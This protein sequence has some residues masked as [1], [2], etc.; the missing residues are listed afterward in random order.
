MS[1]PQYNYP[2]F[3]GYNPV[4]P[5]A[6]R[7]EAPQGFQQPTQPAQQ[8][9]SVATPPSFV[10]RPV[11]SSE[12]AMAIPVDFMGNPMFFPDLAHGVIY[13][14]RFNTQTG[15]ADLFEYYARPAERRTEGSQDTVA[16]APLN[17]L[18]DLKDTVDQLRKDVDGLKKP[19]KA[20]KKSND[21]DE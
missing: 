12:E 16:F 13:V 20:V 4:T 8:P 18:M 7:M 10:C 2:A 9:Q 5:Y 6:P 17:D 11:A 3:G 15:S 14:K 21:A 1:Y 19:A